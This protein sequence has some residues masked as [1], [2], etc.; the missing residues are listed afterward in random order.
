M[1]SCVSETSYY[2]LFATAIL[3]SIMLLISSAYFYDALKNYKEKP[4]DVKKDKR[5][6][7]INMSMVFFGAGLLSI[8]VLFVL[9]FAFQ[10][11]F[12]GVYTTKKIPVTKQ[13]VL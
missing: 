2:I 5:Q 6:V 13:N 12:L 4:E 1:P 7:P 3:I 10:K 8:V 9:F 11:R